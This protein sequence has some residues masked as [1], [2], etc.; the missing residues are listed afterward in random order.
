[1]KA[2]VDRF[3]TSEMETQLKI[4]GSYRPL[5]EALE[6][7]VLRI[8]QEAL[9]NVARHAGVQEVAV[10]IRENEDTLTL[11]IEDRGRGFNARGR[12]P[13]GS[14]GLL[15]MSERVA[16]LGGRFTVDSAPGEGTRVS[17]ELPLGAAPSEEGVA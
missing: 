14:A 5:P 7:E 2:L 6:G 3:S 4:G 10:R 9:T 16:A 12:A 17:A 11:T 1:M 13:T 8:V 15:G